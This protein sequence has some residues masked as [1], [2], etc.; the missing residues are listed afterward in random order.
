[1]AKTSKK[2]VQESA[3]TALLEPETENSEIETPTEPDLNDERPE[4]EAASN[5][6]DFK[7][8][9]EPEPEPETPSKDSSKG[10]RPRKFGDQDQSVL[11]RLMNLETWEGVWAYVYRVQPFSNRLVGGNRKVHVK[12]WDAPF[13]IEDLMKEAGSGVYQVA[14]TRLNSKTGKRP[15]FDSGEIRIFNM[16]HPPKIPPGEWI[17]D[18][19][20]KEWAWA[21]EII[22]RKE[23][24]PA[25]P[26]APDP[27]IG[28]LEKTIDRQEQAMQELRKEMRDNAAAA[29]S[30]GRADRRDYA[31]K[32][33]RP[34]YPAA[35]RT[36]QRPHRSQRAS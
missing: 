12:R 20:N 23:A 32:A 7:A 21:K 14:A 33:S 25:A 4:F 28:L 24:P 30:D 18:P 27:M 13:D 10:G 17:D 6:F 1:V 15:M 9:P 29:R 36:Q 3:Q 35:C 5:N 22:F 26:P 31:V 34:A 19:R 11:D 16:N 2:N 8:D